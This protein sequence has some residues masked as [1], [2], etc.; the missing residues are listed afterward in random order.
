M[1][2]VKLLHKSF[3]D[4]HVLKGVSAT[5]ETGTTNL[6]IGQ[7]GAGKTVLLKCLIGL[8]EPSSG[9]IFFD[10][11]DVT[12]LS[13]DRQK[14]LRKHMGVMFQGS[15]LFDSMTV[16]ENVAFPLELFTRMKY[17]E[18]REVVYDMLEKVGL[19][20]AGRK[21]P[22]EISGGMMK[23]AAIARAL[24]LKP[25]YLFCDEPNSGLD[26]QTAEK[27]DF[28]LRD[29]TREN[30]ITT[31]IN[32][33]DMNSVSNIGEHIIYLHQGQLNWQGSFRDIEHTGTPL[34]KKFIVVPKVE[35][36]AQTGGDKTDRQ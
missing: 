23:R 2:E 35:D 17:A 26:P 28:L 25:K 12:N 13:Q 29:L 19:E 22:N 16:Y 18:R 10:G 1:I 5:F 7:S 15:A 3:E 6:I 31:V 30:H 8:V 21:L 27:I 14:A 33:H 11:E 32:T 34:L 36:V 9:E 4:K 20:S 24:I